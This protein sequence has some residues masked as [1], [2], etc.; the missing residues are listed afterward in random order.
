VRVIGW[1]G[2]GLAVAQDAPAPAAPVFNADTVLVTTFQPETPDA[3]ADVDRLYHLLADRLGQSNAV[4]PMSK[5]PRFEPQGYDA[6]VYM[7]GCPPGKYAGC[8]LVLGQRAQT[9]RAIGCT[10]RR[11]PD[12]FEVGKTNLV[13]TVHLVD[14][15]E[16]SE[17]ASFALPVPPD[18]EPQTVEGIARLFDDVVH[19]D[20][21]RRD[22][23]P[24]GPSADEVADEKARQQQIAASLSEL[25]QQLGTAVRTEDVGR[26]EP[27]RVTKADL[28]AYEGREE[29]PPWQPLGLSPSQYRRY[30]NSHQDIQSWRTTGQGRFAKVVF[31]ATAG[32]GG[33]PWS[34]SYRAQTLLSEADL[35]PVDSVQFVEVVDH[36]AAVGDLELGLGVTPWLDVTFAAA[37]RN[38]QAEYL[39]D[40]DV[41]NQISVPSRPTSYAM[42]SWQEGVRATFAPFPR[43]PARPT[44]AVGVARWS[45]AG[46]PASDRFPRL[47]APNAT[48]VEVLP[49]VEADATPLVA[50]TL[51]GLVSVPVASTYVRQTDSG[52]PTMEDRP[53]P[54]G[55][56]GI[57]V[58]VEAGLVFR[59]GP[60]FQP[61]TRAPTGVFEDDEP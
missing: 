48:L 55:E 1:W 57:G 15:A 31:R 36:G 6:A 24:D 3:D 56:R 38:G 20:Y 59:I 58:G 26:I 22:V 61:P 7:R 14:V 49:G 25:E 27:P 51:R 28:A 33:G 54:N 46:I 42:S 50:L 18:K 13:I 30:A 44:A 53:Q 43:W 12:E 32:G 29:T 60:L 37:I 39:R 9:D 10:V 47:A 40:E 5:V 41:Q 19:G 23:R 35:Q 8:A 2:A 45:G 52:T 21:E 16:A 11:D 34:E 4:V 17:V